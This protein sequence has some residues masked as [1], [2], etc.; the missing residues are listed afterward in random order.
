M[1]ESSSDR[2]SMV[3]ACRWARPQWRVTID[4]STLGVVSVN[5]ADHHCSNLLAAGSRARRRGRGVG[6]EDVLPLPYT[7][8]LS[9]FQCYC[10]AHAQKTPWSSKLSHA[11][12]KKIDNQGWL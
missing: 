9:F 10:S 3:R 6:V 12:P 11:V 5:E 8:S 4:S 1:G 7:N 2:E